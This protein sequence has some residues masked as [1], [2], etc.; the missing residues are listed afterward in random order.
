MV[1]E[2]EYIGVVLFFT[3]LTLAT[4]IGDQLSLAMLNKLAH[5]N[6][7]AIASVCLPN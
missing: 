7:V 5:F 4:F 3:S 2:V 1:M 6:R